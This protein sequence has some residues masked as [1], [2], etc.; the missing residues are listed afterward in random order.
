MQARVDSR[1]TSLAP[2]L[3]GKRRRRHLHGRL[4]LLDL[5]A[6]HRSGLRLN[7]SRIAADLDNRRTQYVFKFEK[8]RSYD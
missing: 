2:E 6:L 1:L 7:Y 8:M 5:C 3:G 4:W